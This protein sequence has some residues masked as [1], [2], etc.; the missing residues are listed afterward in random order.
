VPPL[1]ADNARPVELPWEEGP[2]L[3]R[4]PATSASPQTPSEPQSPSQPDATAAWHDAPLASLDLETTGR[5]PASDRILAIALFRQDPG[6]SPTPIVDTL[7]DPG[8]EVAIPDEAA[9]VHGI[10]RERLTAEDAPPL[11]VVLLEVHAAL[12]DLA[13]DGI[14]V[15]I[16]NAPFDWPFLAAE[17]ARLDPPLQLPDCALVD[18]L[19]L[20]RHVDRYRKGK[21][22]LEAA[23][24]HYG[25]V[26]DDAHEAAADALASLGVARAI[27]RTYPDIGGLS[28]QELHEVQVQAHGVWKDSFN[29][30]LRR[31]GADREPVTGSWPDR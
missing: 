8:A 2:L 15:V 30:Y 12:C 29:A 23:A 28:P 20:D 4:G 11:D 21:R 22:T 10:T 24:E 27:G 19:V 14:A 6:Q 31:I 3:D 5:D 7:V 9:A 26:L 18:P 13:A 25:V 16:Y 1:T 17:L